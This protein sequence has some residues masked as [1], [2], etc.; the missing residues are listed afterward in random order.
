VPDEAKPPSVNQSLLALL[1]DNATMRKLIGTWPNAYLPSAKRHEQVTRWAALTM[2][3][4]VEVE[5]CWRAL[6][7]N[8]F[9]RRDGTV[10]AMAA[11]YCAAIPMGRLPA[12]ARSGRKEKSDG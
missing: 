10:D 8:G 4:E 5:D 11:K 9:C 1:D 3:R 6:F 2:L 12:A 7:E